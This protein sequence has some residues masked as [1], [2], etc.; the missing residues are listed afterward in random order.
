[1]VVHECN[2]VARDESIK[3][4]TAHLPS[5]CDTAERLPETILA[6]VVRWDRH[7]LRYENTYFHDLVTPTGSGRSVDLSDKRSV[8]TS[9][10]RGL[11]S[12]VPYK[13]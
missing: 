8:V 6:I 13:Q 2:H 11:F 3:L 4:P 10:S 12:F 5:P 1:M 9:I 7:V